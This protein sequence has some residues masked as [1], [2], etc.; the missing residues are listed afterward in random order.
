VQDGLN[1]FIRRHR[2][3][4]SHAERLLDRI[5]REGLESLLEKEVLEFG[6]IYRELSDNLV[7]ARAEFSNPEMVEYLNAL[8]GRGY[9]VIYRGRRHRFKA[10]LRFLRSG[11]PRLCRSRKLEIGFASVAFLAGMVFGGVAGLLDPESVQYMVEKQYASVTTSR[12]LQSKGSLTGPDEAALMMGVIS[13]NNMRVA[14]AAFALG[15]TMGVGTLAV[16]FY[17]GVMLASFSSMFV[18]EGTGFELFGLLA[19]HGLIEMSAMILSGAAG[20]IL[21]RALLAPGRRTRAL[22]LRE[23]GPKALQMMAGSIPIILVAMVIEST[24]SKFQSVGAV[25][26]SALGFLALAGMLAWL[27]LGGKDKDTAR[28][29]AVP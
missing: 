9:A 29:S 3:M 4:W 13:T 25:P 17:N 1:D 23:D 20:L 8:V 5:E 26:K 16:L 10:M 12:Y 24:F 15:I 14:F 2:P 28:E 6:D 7:R 11:Y 19:P 21:G 18:R 27:L 22:A